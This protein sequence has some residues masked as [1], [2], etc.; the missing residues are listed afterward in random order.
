M[1]SDSQLFFGGFKHRKLVE[2]ESKNDLICYSKP[3]YTPDKIK[4]TKVSKRLIV[5]VRWILFS[6]Y[7]TGKRN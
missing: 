4:I 1:K 6:R 7:C 3:N 2:Y 5:E